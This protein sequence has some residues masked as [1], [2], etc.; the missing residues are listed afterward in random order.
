MAMGVTPIVANTG[1]LPE[2]LRDFGLADGLVTWGAPK[3]TYLKALKAHDRMPNDM[4][5][6]RRWEVAR[7]LDFDN[8]YAEWD[9]MIIETSLDDNKNGHHNFSVVS[10]T[11]GGN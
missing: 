1:A 6:H 11:S 5:L 9:R 8:L 4:E 10:Q 3:K 2:R 7:E